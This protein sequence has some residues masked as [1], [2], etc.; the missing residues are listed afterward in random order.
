[1]PKPPFDIIG[2]HGNS[3]GL[4]ARVR[5]A[6]LRDRSGRADLKRKGPALELPRCRAFLLDPKHRLKQ[7]RWPWAVA[8][9]VPNGGHAGPAAAAGAICIRNRPGGGSVAGNWMPSPVAGCAPRT[10]SS[11][12]QAWSIT[13]SRT[14]VIP[15]HSGKSSPGHRRR[16]SKAYVPSAIAAPSASATRALFDDLGM[17]TDGAHPFNRRRDIPP[18]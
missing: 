4:R 6:M 12:P 1:M 8:A 5:S 7:A 10:G 17:P 9:P 18:V 16:R 14:A 3:T 15:R 11:Y 2:I 13:S